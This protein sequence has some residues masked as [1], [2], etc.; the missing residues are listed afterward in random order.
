LFH[1]S[2]LLTLACGQALE[3]VTCD[4]VLVAEDYFDST[5]TD[6]IRTESVVPA[7]AMKSSL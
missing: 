7:M 2:T 3:T 5:V 4:F 1:A 6:V